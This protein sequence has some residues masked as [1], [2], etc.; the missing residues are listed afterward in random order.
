MQ[1]VYLLR[2]AVVTPLAI[3]FG[4]F[5]GGRA[6]ALPVGDYLY[7]GSA[8]AQRGATT[9]AGRLLRHATRSA[10]R[11]P[12]AVRG[13]LVKALQ[14][15]DQRVTLPTAKRVRWHIDYLLDEAAADLR[16]IYA[17]RTASPIE[18]PLARWLMAEPVTAVV[19]PRLGASDDR[20]ATHLLQVNAPTTWWEAL[21]T[22]LQQQHWTI[23][24]IHV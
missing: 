12:H 6:I 10:D 1:G 14:A 23:Y 18:V 21:P 15:A 8:M 13:E 16:Q 22:V 20:G 17:L 9:L 3:P 11:A 7:I 2:I 5:A 4:R 19:A 24:T